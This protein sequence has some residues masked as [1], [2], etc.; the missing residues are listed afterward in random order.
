MALS[1]TGP[2]AVAVART[3]ELLFRPFDLSKWIYLGFGSWLVS[4]SENGGGLQ[5]PVNFL[6]GSRRGDPGKLMEDLL[7]DLAG[8]K[9][10]SWAPLIVG[11]L[12]T[13]VVL[14]LALTWL[15]SR[16]RFMFLDNVVRN[17]MAVQQPWRT[18]RRDAF[19]FFLWRVTALLC[20]S[21]V[22]LAGFGFL[23][24]S[25]LR[26]LYGTGVPA[27]LR[28]FPLLPIDQLYLMGA[29]VLAVAILAAVFLVL[30]DDFVLLLMWKHRVPAT[31]AWGLLL[32]V[33]AAHP[34]AVAGYLILK[35]LLYVGIWMGILFMS[36]LS[37][38][39]GLLVLMIPFVNAVVLL[40]VSVFFQLNAVGFL[41]QAGPDFDAFENLTSESDPHTEDL[42]PPLEGRA[43]DPDN[44]YSPLR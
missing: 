22:F 28:S 33:I 5:L 39:V 12:A 23:V 27:L 14:G 35:V 38:C 9:W 15:S 37:C 2:V 3:R 40:P 17:R 24:V 13:A 8:F 30:L 34:A 31:Q 32:P 25:A 7:R 18:Y 26:H 41:A 19:S 36:L 4:L 16:G 42:R 10:E 21:I 43:G 29:G 44:P 1:V 20:F 6:G 11:T